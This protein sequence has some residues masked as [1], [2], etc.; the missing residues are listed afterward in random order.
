MGADGAVAHEHQI[1]VEEILL[2]LL[3]HFLGFYLLEVAATVG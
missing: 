3:V 2:E 1:A